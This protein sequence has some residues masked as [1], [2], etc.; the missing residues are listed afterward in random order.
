MFEEHISKNIYLHGHQAEGISYVPRP[1]GIEEHKSLCFS[2]NR[3][4]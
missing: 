4:T 1:C 2:G 3:G